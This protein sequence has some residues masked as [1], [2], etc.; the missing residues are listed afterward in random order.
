M[1][2]RKPLA[3]IGAFAVIL[4]AILLFACGHRAGRLFQLDY[5]DF[6]NDSSIPADADTRGSEGPLPPVFSLDELLANAPKG[7]RADDQVISLGSEYSPEASGS[8]SDREY[9]IEVED[10]ELHLRAYEPG[11]YTYA[12]F[13]QTVGDGTWGGGQDDDIPLQSL[14]DT[15]TCSFGGGQDDDI[16]LVYFLGFADYSLGSW[17][18]Y[19]PFGSNDEAIPLST[20]TLMSR[21]KSPNDNFYAKPRAAC[22]RM[23]WSA[24]CRSRRNPAKPARAV[25]IRAE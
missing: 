12:V 24:H 13:A 8:T 15:E 6:A 2:G 20:D 22:R 19:G 16:P 1:P 23:G 21:F 7:V 10:T 3:L 4:T 11:D 14:L 18:W 17:R 25:R 9:S 5:S